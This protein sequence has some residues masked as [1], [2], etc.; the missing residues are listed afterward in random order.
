MIRHIVALRFKPGT[1]AATKASLYRDLSGLAK[2]IEGIVDFRSFANISVELPLARGFD[3]LFWFDFRD[4]SVRDTYLA[5]AAHQAIG[6]RI[7]AE[8]DGG[9]EGVFVFDVTL[10]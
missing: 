5:D 7:V 10:G 3:D 9:A 6:A 8:L 1:T 4:E 2:H